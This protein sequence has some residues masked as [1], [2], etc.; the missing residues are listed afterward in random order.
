MKLVDDTAKITAEGILGARKFA[1]AKDR[2]MIGGNTPETVLIRAQRIG[3]DEGV[4]PVV[5][6]PGNSVAIAKTIELFR[7]ESEDC[8]VMLKKRVHERTTRNFY[9]YGYPV[10]L[11][12]VNSSTRR[13]KSPIA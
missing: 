5:L 1:N 7:I 3:S 6:S 2:R 12:F 13:R 8:A 10:W 11:R 4:A 9:G